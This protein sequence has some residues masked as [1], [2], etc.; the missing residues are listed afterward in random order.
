MSMTAPLSYNLLALK[1]MISK[2]SPLVICEILGVVVNTLT[3][4]DKYPVSDCK[5]LLLPIQKQFS[6]K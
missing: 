2:T 5:N 3:A 4:D 6:S 1:E